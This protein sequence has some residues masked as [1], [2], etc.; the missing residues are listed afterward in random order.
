MDE[1]KT[2]PRSSRLPPAGLAPLPQ[3][4]PLDSL[5][6][7][8]IVPTF[9]KPKLP[10][11]VPIQAP[12]SAETPQPP[13]PSSTTAAANTN[14]ALPPPPPAPPATAVPTTSLP[15]D[16][17]AP[18]SIDDPASP[19]TAPAK[20][21]ATT[22]PALAEAAAAARPSQQTQGP[23]P[24]PGQTDA[25]HVQPAPTQSQA[26]QHEGTAAATTPPPLQP[27]LIQ[28][29]ATPSNGPPLTLPGAVPTT[30]VGSGQPNLQVKAGPQPPAAPA[31]AAAAAG[32]TP[33][34]RPTSKR[35]P[36]RDPPPPAAVEHMSVT[37]D[38]RTVEQYIPFGFVE[39]RGR[40]LADFP[41]VFGDPSV[42]KKFVELCKWMSLRNTLRLAID[43]GDADE[44]YSP[45]DPD[46]DTL[47]FKAASVE[48][49]S[50]PAVSSTSAVAPAPG[51]AKSLMPKSDLKSMVADLYDELDKIL[52]KAEFSE[53]PPEDLERATKHKSLMGLE[54]IPASSEYLE[55]R[56]HYR[57]TRTKKIRFRRWGLFRRQIEMN[58]YERLAI[59]FRLKKPVSKDDVPMEAASS[60]S[61][62]IDTRPWYRRLFW[63]VQGGKKGIM[64]SEFK[65]P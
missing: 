55:H 6:G 1:E 49:T 32:P 51:P 42:S 3:R 39:L 28:A 27:M 58:V 63:Q 52:E 59:C 20:A 16:T 34:S 43:Y 36:P 54:V 23:Q 33:A 47:A 13:L 41:E 50:P 17:R 24:P 8:P 45:L 2:P 22:E 12:S 57:G 14:P 56:I 25:P 29:D 9:S 11:T 37:T 61:A 10:T 18:A 21:T 15:G 26:A 60:N 48:E 35:E 65:V 30:P 53:L 31:A 19:R 40:L 5:G 38:C 64:V 62:G 4:P 44:K 7:Q 46:K